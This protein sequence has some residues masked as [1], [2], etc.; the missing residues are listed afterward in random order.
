RSLASPSPRTAGTSHWPTPTAPYTFFGYTNRSCPTLEVRGSRPVSPSGGRKNPAGAMRKSSLSC[1]SRIHYASRDLRNR[2]LDEN[3]VMPLLSVAD[4]VQALV[5]NP[6]L[7]QAQ[8]YE[9]V[10]IL[11]PRYPEPRDLARD[12]LQRGWLTAYQINQLFQDRGHEL[13]LGDYLLVER[14][15]EGG[16]GQVF[17]AS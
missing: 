2:P 15:G 10:H 9:V 5:Q 14:L 13:I 6:L 8:M 1:L 3:A 17:K 11:Q 12:L 4:L 7:D 16:M